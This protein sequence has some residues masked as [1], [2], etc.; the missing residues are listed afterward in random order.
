MRRSYIQSYES[1]LEKFLDTANWTSADRE[2]MELLAAVVRDNVEEELE[3]FAD[4]EGHEYDN[5]LGLGGDPMDITAEDVSDIIIE[6]AFQGFQEAGPLANAPGIPY[7]SPREI[8]AYGLADCD[9]F[10][11]SSST[12]QFLC[13][14]SEF[15]EHRFGY[16]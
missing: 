16:N 1:G 13:T 12:M 3:I 2:K 8:L 10:G 14:M 4:E 15:L 11:G 9:P 6:R 7:Y 5:D